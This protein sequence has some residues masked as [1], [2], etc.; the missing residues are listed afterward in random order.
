MYTQHGNGPQ[1]SWS[2]VKKSTTSP[3]TWALATKP[4]VPAMLLAA[5]SAALVVGGVADLASGTT[6]LE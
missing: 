5:W 1:R 2:F 6:S 3:A 4:N